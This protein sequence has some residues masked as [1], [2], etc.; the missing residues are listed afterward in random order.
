MQKGRRDR[1]FRYA[2]G[3]YPSQAFAEYP[4]VSPTARTVPLDRRAGRPLPQ[5]AR[6]LRRRPGPVEPRHDL[7]P[8]LRPLLRLP[9]PGRASG[10]GARGERL[11]ARAIPHAPAADPR[12]LART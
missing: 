3:A 5:L 4:R 8:P 2:W 10:P 7:P 9:A 1:V 11:A 6:A 12:T